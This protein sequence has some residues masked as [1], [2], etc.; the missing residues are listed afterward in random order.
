[1]KHLEMD[2]KLLFTINVHSFVD[3]IT[4]S[5]SE[6]FVESSNSKET[7]IALIKEV[8][9]RYLDE[10]EELRSLD[11]LST[12]E[13]EQY[14]SYAYEHYSNPMKLSKKFDIDPIM[15]YSNWS[16]KD[17]A[18]YWFPRISDVGY[19]LIKE[20]L[21]PNLY[22]LFSIDD[23]PEWEMQ[24]KLMLIMNRYHLG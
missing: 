24:E 18:R 2:K 19:E 3:V 16:E 15:L 4:N 5:S 13:L 6:L 8:Y 12:G 17:T 11:E 23:N 20:R 9:P 1:M 14:I 21:N 10:Y 22:F 7:L